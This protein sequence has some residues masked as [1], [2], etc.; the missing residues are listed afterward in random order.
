MDWMM[1][2]AWSM[3]SGVSD[4]DAARR[5]MAASSELVSDSGI[6]V[7]MRLLNWSRRRSWA[8]GFVDC[9]CGSGAVI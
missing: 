3:W 4:P 7:P 6:A 9:G 5:G 2:R 8:D 1:V